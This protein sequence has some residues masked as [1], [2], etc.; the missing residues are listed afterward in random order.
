[1]DSGVIPKMF[2]DFGFEFA[3]IFENESVSAVSETLLMQPQQFLKKIIGL[4]DTVPHKLF[5]RYRKLSISAMSENNAT[6]MAS[7]VPETL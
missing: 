7:S 1:M 5:F 6:D 3:D 2:F 4:S